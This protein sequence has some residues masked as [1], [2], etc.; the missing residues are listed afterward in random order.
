MSGFSKDEHAPLARGVAG[1]PSAVVQ[2]L[3]RVF[4]KEKEKRVGRGVVQKSGF[5]MVSA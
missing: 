1:D 5:P 3:A 4:K 2:H